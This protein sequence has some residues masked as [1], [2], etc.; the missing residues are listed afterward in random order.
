MQEILILYRARLVC[1]NL[2]SNLF[3]R[4]FAFALASWQED[5]FELH[6]LSHEK[7]LG[8]NSH[9]LSGRG[10]QFSLEQKKNSF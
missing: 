5:G 10:M 8:T 9:N 4:D 2:C 1:M 3:P 7:I 6:A